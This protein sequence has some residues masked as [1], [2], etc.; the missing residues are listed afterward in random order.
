MVVVIGAPMV[1]L[2]DMTTGS[3]V[4]SSILASRMMGPLSQ[5][6][7]VMT[8]WQ[9]AKVALQGLH[10]IMKLPIDQAEGSKRVHLPVVRGA[11]EFKQA[12]FKYSEEAPMPALTVK[13]L[14][15]APGE[16]IAV[17]GRNGAGKST[18]L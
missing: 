13:A 6:T 7:L 5:I 3:L 4:A 2:G 18:L 15:I 9:Q 17:L 14:K 16:R 10:R 12:V 8:R 11:Y 1:M